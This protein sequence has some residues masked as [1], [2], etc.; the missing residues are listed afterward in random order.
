MTEL[1]TD[2]NVLRVGLRDIEKV[3]LIIVK[4]ARFDNLVC[5]KRISTVSGFIVANTEN[6]AILMNV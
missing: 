5:C 6:A 2:I 4:I 1:E 3:Y